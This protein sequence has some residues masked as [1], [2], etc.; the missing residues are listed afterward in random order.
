[1]LGMKQT[2]LSICLI[3]FVLPSW[4]EDNID[5]PWSKKSCTE[6][7]NAI[8]IF[9]SLADKEWKKDEEKAARYTLAAANYATIYE[10]VCKQK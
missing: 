9:A 3:L 7:Y 8:A 2:F 4:G 10:T 6:V 5:K 1:M